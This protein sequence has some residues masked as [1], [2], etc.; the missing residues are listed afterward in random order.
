[1]YVSTLY[2][3]G[4]AVSALNHWA[5]SLASDT[6]FSIPAQNIMTKKQVGE[7]RVYSI[8]PSILLF[9]TKGS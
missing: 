6:V 9:I 1:M 5:I 8:Y 7:G 4:R 2:L 3:S